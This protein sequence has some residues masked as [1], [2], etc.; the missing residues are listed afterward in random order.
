[1]DLSSNG[2]YVNEMLVGRDEAKQGRSARLVHGDTIGLLELDFTVYYFMQESAMKLQHPQELNCRYLVARNSRVALRY[3]RSA[4]CSLQGLHYC[5][6]GRT[7]QG[8]WTLGGG[9]YLGE[10]HL[11]GIHWGCPLRWLV[12]C[13]YYQL[14]I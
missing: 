8:P 13:H 11:E 7:G 14:A 5:R 1:M 3:S 2:T 9:G 10:L 12:F 6:C 4:L